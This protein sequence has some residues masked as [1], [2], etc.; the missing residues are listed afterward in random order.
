V[1]VVV[2]EEEAFSAIIDSH[3]SARGSAISYASDAS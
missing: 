2:A 1:T 3:T